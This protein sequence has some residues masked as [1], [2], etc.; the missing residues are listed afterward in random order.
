MDEAGD[1]SPQPRTAYG[2]SEPHTKHISYL[3]HPTSEEEW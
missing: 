3:Y 1:R 2:G